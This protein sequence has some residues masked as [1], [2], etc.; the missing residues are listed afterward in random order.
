MYD[1]SQ[2]PVSLLVQNP[3]REWGES[4]TRMETQPFNLTPAWDMLR[5][6]YL[7]IATPQPSLGLAISLAIRNEAVLIGQAGDWYLYES[8]ILRVPV[9]APD[10]WPPTPHP[11]TL[12]L[13]VTRAALELESI[14][15][16]RPVL[17]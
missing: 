16:G 12:H 6:K 4:I 5:Y 1:Y 14:E 9:T 2:S 10:A 13:E 15:Q 11:P 17:P 7:L 8:R 3:K